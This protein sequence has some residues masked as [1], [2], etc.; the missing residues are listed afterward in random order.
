MALTM[1]KLYLVLRKEA[2]EEVADFQKQL[3]DVK[4]DLS[5]VKAIT[6][7]TLA[8]VAAMF[9]RTFLV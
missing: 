8:L 1:S 5:V 4:A 6:A 3:S 9:V 7:A 2:A